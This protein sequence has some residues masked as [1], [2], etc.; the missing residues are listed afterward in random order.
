MVI[1][2]YD[3]DIQ[4]NKSVINKLSYEDSF[5]NT[6]YILMTSKCL[7]DYQYKSLTISCN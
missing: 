5:A 4:Y 1:E 6:S 3:L 7:K 2:K